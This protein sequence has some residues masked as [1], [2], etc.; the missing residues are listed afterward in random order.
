[1]TI[2]DVARWPSH[3]V[4]PKGLQDEH[5]P[6]AEGVL[7]DLRFWE[8]GSNI[9]LVVQCPDG[10]YYAALKTIRPVSRNLILFLL[11]NK[12]RQLN[13]ILRAEIDSAEI[14]H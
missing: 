9:T 3:W 13:E 7:I 11:R 10:K 1:M 6:V 12:G 5:A 2:R 14:V 4:S 8:G